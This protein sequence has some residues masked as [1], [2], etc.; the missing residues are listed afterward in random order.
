MTPVTF[1]AQLKS[2]TTRTLVSNDKSTV[3]KLETVER[4]AGV[5]DQLPPDVNVI[6]TITE[7]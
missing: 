3:I 5:L 4:I 7:E 1:L 2:V 6:V